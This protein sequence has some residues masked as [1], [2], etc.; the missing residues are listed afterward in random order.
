MTP[1]NPT[2]QARAR[3][4]AQALF[5]LEEG[6]PV[7]LR[8]PQEAGLQRLALRIARQ[9]PPVLSRAEIE[10][11]WRRVGM[12]APELPIR[13]PHYTVSRGGML[14]TSRLP[15]ELD[16]ARGGVLILADA[17]EFSNLEEIL[18]RASDVYV[19]GTAYDCPCDYAPDGE[20]ACTPEEL[21]AYEEAVEG[22]FEVVEVE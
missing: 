12:P 1:P 6:Y 22:L 16:L 10:K 14:G 2:P 8:G 4:E 7:L 18:E 20:C 9:L 13:R 11:T 17:P 19:L 21:R 5:L 3:A 15:G